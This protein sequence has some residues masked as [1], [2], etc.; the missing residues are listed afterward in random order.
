MATGRK[1]YEE[2]SGRCLDL[3][4]CLVRNDPSA[5]FIAYKPH[6]HLQRDDA[7][8]NEPN[9]GFGNRG[10]THMDA[11]PYWKE[12]VGTVGKLEFGGHKGQLVVGWFCYSV[13]ILFCCVFIISGI[14]K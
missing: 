10:M 12:C 8:E 3:I 9:V 14:F 1:I 4:N 2:P 6:P 7:I 13:S 5:Q 11:K